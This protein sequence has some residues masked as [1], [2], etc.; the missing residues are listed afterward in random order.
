MAEPDVASSDAMNISIE[1][2]RDRDNYV[3]NGS[4]C[5]PLCANHQS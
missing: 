1:M 4:V 5:L 2:K 3:L